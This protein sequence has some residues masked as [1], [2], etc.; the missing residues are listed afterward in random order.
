MKTLD[1]LKRE[2]LE[3]PETR[4]VYDELEQQFSISRGIDSS[5]V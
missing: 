4:R 3:D 1:D 5:T 2:L